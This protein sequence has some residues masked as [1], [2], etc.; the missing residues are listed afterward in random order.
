MADHGHY[1]GAHGFDGR[2]FGAFEEIYRIPL[3]IAGSGISSAAHCEAQ[4]SI[5]DIAAT[6]CDLGDAEPIDVPDSRSFQP[7]L[8][9]PDLIAPE[10]QT[11]YAECH[12][13]RFPLM[14]RILWKGD[15]KFVFNGFDFDEL[16]NLRDH[17]EEVC[18]LAADVDQQHRIES[19]MAEIWSR[20]GD[21]GDR[22]ILESQYFSMRLVCVGPSVA[23]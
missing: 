15:W 11:G 19:R 1:V 5:A 17:P 9:Q 2:N 18:N 16:Y 12:G 23:L 6:L 13:T 10:F 20:V 3:I 14:Q 21:T 7:L 22:A 8:A 4:L